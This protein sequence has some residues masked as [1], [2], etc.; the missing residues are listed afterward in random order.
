MFAKRN[1]KVMATTPTT[2]DP[3]VTENGDNKPHFRALLRENWVSVMT[4]CL[5][6]GSFGMGV[7]ILGPTL[8]DLGCQ[9]SASLRE[10]QWVFFV[11]LLLTLV[12][13]VSA[14]CLAQRYVSLSLFTKSFTLND[15]S[16]DFYSDQKTKNVFW[17]FKFTTI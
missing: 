2:F 11:Q 3:R 1:T 12:G 13:S 7:A 15:F 17:M 6:F 8:F 10:L 4:D 14:G 9:T 5:V 16:K